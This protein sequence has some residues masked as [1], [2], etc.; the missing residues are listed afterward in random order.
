MM[1]S[2]SPQSQSQSQSLKRKQPSQ[3]PSISSFFT[4]ATPGA[5]SAASSSTTTAKKAKDSGDKRETGKDADNKK[6][7]TPDITNENPEEDNEDEE[8]EDVVLPAQKRARING[9]KAPTTS[10]PRT[11]EEKKKA[12]ETTVENGHEDAMDTAPVEV[13]ERGRSNQPTSSA[14]RADKFRFGSS[15]Q[16]DDLDGTDLERQKREKERLHEK[17]VKRLGGADCTIGIGRRGAAD[18]DSAVAGE[19]AEGD[20]DEEPAPPPS[21]AKGGKKGG[22]KLTPM[23]KQ[24]I[25][26]K[27]KHMDTVLVVEV[28]YKFRFFG[29]DAKI[30]AKELSIVCIPGKFRFDERTCLYSLP[31]LYDTRVKALR[32]CNSSMDA[33][34][35]LVFPQILQKHTWTALH[36]LPFP[37]TDYTFMSSV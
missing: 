35:F 22:G 33:N 32:N 21:K 17:F 19:D 15:P 26:I 20:E 3:Q 7:A 1:P 16:R 10:R 29:E 37:C 8:D 9:Y 6:S 27:R 2:S 31:P 18:E 11:V 4:R 14:G 25:E 30:A 23:E 28:G 24:V 13:E 34:S 12:P 36:Q 5:S